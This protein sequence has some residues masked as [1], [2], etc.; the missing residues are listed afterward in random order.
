MEKQQQRQV[1]QL[2][3]QQQQQADDSDELDY[4]SL[5]GVLSEVMHLLGTSDPNKSDFQLFADNGANPIQKKF[6]RLLGAIEV[7]DLSNAMKKDG[8]QRFIKTIKFHELKGHTLDLNVLMQDL[9]NSFKPCLVHEAQIVPLIPLKGV[10]QRSF[11]KCKGWPSGGVTT[12]EW[13]RVQ[14]KLWESGGDYKDKANP[15]Y[16]LLQM[17]KQMNLMREFYGNIFSILGL[18]GGRLFAECFVAHFLKHHYK[19][20]PK[21]NLGENIKMLADA[22]RR[23]GKNDDD[24]KWYTDRLERLH[25]FGNRTGHLELP[26]LEPQEKPILIQTVFELAQKLP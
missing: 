20:S 18:S 23:N 10:S 21:K 14:L 13:A 3:L 1:Q 24:I 2:Q 16:Y 26:E 9:K 19:R 15:N 8:V 22:M 4:G 6:L 11:E 12:D 7:V 25:S 17:A 5:F